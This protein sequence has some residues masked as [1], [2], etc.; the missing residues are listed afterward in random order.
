MHCWWV[1]KLESNL[2]VP[3]TTEHV[4]LLGPKNPTSKNYSQKSSLKYP[5]MFTA[6]LLIIFF[7]MQ[8]IQRPSIE[9]RSNNKYK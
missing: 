7:K 8:T 1:H 6:A 3:T 2:A 5:R 4:H 9:Y